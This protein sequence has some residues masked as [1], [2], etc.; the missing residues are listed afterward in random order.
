MDVQTI[1]VSDVL[2]GDT[3]PRKSFD[4]DSLNELAESV[5]KHGLIHPITVRPAGDENYELISGERRLEAHKKAGLDEI[6]A[7]IR[8][9]SD[10]LAVD[11]QFV[12]NIQREEVH[13][14]EEAE[15]FK[16]LREHSDYSIK[17]IGQKV[18]KSNTFVLQRLKLND[19]IADFQDEFMSNQDFQIGHGLLLAKQPDKVQQ[20]IFDKKYSEDSFNY[21]SLTVSKLKTIIERHFLTDLD[22]AIFDLTDGDLDPDAGPCTSCP[23]RSGC[24]PELFT[25]ANSDDVCYDKEC[26]KNKTNKQLRVLVEENKKGEDMLFCRHG[27]NKITKELEQE[28][29][30]VLEKYD[31]FREPYLEDGETHNG[32]VGLMLTGSEKGQIINIS[33]YQSA[34]RK[35]KV[36]ANEKVKDLQAKLEREKELK[37]ERLQKDLND[38]VEHRVSFI[39]NTEGIN[40]EYLVFLTLAYVVFDRLGYEQQ[41]EIRARFDIGENRGRNVAFMEALEQKYPSTEELYPVINK[42]IRELAVDDFIRP[43]YVNPDKDVKPFLFKRFAQLYY[44][45]EVQELEA[46]HEEKSAKKQERYQERIEQA[47]GNR[48]PT[49]EE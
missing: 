29:Y 28:G 4:A 1:P 25:E 23:K 11:L 41:K 8:E 34:S 45:E 30:Q 27:K 26:F 12:E 21:H 14:M 48:Q 18:G 22:E 31:D 3:N 42:M 2:I 16:S 40:D 13:P 35:T 37:V 20:T 15:A 32:P 7:D 38:M 24:N 47:K 33:L 46:T 49:E 17:D 9:V 44:P 6:D 19:L 43:S 36:P 5:Q 39:H 10:E